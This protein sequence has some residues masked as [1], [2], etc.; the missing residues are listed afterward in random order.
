MTPVPSVAFAA[1]LTTLPQMGPSRLRAVMDGAGGDGGRRDAEAAWRAIA[2]GA[3]CDDVLGALRHSDPR[4]LARAW[5]DA[6]HSTDPAAVLDAC[7]AGAIRVVPLGDADYP[8]LLAD[9]PEPPAVLFVRG[10]LGALEYR[11]AAVVGTRRCTSSGA[12][13]AAQLGRVLASAGVA[14]VSGLALGIDGAA[15]TGA[16]AADG[17]PPIGVVGSGL[18]VVYPRRHRVLWD[19]VAARGVLI[20][21]APPGA[22]PERWRFPARNRILAALSEVVVVVESHVRGGSQHTVDAAVERDVPVMA[23]PGSV[24][25]PAAE[26]TNLLLADGVPPVLDARDV[27]VAL[28]VPPP[29]SRP[30]VAPPSDA[31]GVALLDALGDEPASIDELAARTGRPVPAVAAGLQRLQA[32]GGVVLERGWW[33]RAVDKSDQTIS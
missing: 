28:G 23:V 7:T 26:G 4:T 11:R 21:E 24:R 16:L 2:D 13:V 30:R 17:A 25:C 5:R 6:T 3:L 9:D 29:R 32:V 14:V 33:R 1:A 31:V 15:H 19:R 27:L 20:S 10:D 18:D 8:G 22:R 12:S